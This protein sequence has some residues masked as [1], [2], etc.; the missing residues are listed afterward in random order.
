MSDLASRNALIFSAVGHAFMHYFTAMYF[1]IAVTLGKSAW[2]GLTWSEASEL[3]MLG[4]LLVGLAALPAGWLADRWS[5]RGMMV[6]YFLGMGACAILCGLVEAPLA[7]M[8]GL[9]GV[10]LFA[11]IY[12]PVGIPWVVRNAHTRRGKALG[13]NGVFGQVGWASAGLIT[14][15]LIDAFS[16]QVAFIAPGLVSLA[17]GLLLLAFWLAGGVGEGDAE[18]GPKTPAR[19][20]IMAR[21]AS[22]RPQRT[23]PAPMPRK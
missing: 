19:P 20:S 12:H 21:G 2:A 17:A 8:L 3:W 5:S 11:A 13:L 10:G 7:M 14:G 18:V 6:V 22:T 16:W 9:A 15:V 23:A 1:V 4:A